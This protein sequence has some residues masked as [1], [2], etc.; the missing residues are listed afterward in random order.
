[1]SAAGRIQT[2]IVG[3]GLMGFW[4]ADAAVRAGAQVA[5]VVD[6]DLSQARRLASRHRICEATTDLDAALVNPSVRVF[7]V[8]TPR[9]THVPV[10]NDVLD[11]GRHLLVEKPMAPT[12][13][14]TQALQERARAH[15]VLLCPVHQY[16]FQSGVR[17]AQQLVATIGPLRHVDAVTCSAGGDVGSDA[18]QDDIVSEILPHPLSLFAR[19]TGQVLTDIDWTLVHQRPGELRV[20]GAG[21]GISFGI[22]VSLRGRPTRNTARMIGERGSVDVDLY[23]GFSVLEPGS[24]SR[25]RKVVRPFSRSAHTFVR[26]GVNLVARASRWEP[27]FPGLR[28]LVGGFYRAVTEDGDAPIS[29]DEAL[30]VA[31]ARDE[32]LRRM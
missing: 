19:V 6:R 17:R 13:E 16:L 30:A 7:H 28:E 9:A 32:L 14:A 23:H 3:A 11:A 18:E 27:A 29:T 15:G 4:H 25:F 21:Q 20:A 8:C 22:V 31:A 5:V 2:A 10:A 24:V 26:G 1:M 12:A